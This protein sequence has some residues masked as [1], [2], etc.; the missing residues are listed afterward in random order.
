MSSK[1]SKGLVELNDPMLSGFQAEQRCKL[2]VAF[3]HPEKMKAR[4][5]ID[6]SN[7]IFKKVLTGQ[8]APSDAAT[9]CMRIIQVIYRTYGKINVLLTYNLS[10][11]IL[12][13]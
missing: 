7:G 10:N 9:I 12:T 8:S 13:L 4:N 6:L 3:D 11:I 2:Q 5:Y 1:K